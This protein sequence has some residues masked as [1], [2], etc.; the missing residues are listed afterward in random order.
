MEKYVDLKGI[1]SRREET[2]IIC[3]IYGKN[4]ELLTKGYVYNIHNGYYSHKVVLQEN[5]EYDIIEI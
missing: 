4:Q 5:G 2:G 1:R 3:R